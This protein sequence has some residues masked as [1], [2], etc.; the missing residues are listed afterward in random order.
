MSDVAL[1]HRPALPSRALLWA[2]LLALFVGAPLLMTAFFGRYS[3]FAVLWLLAGVAA[4]L[5]W[6]TP[7]FRWRALLR[8]PVLGEWR[9]IA[10]FTLF[11]A[12]IAAA[13]AQALVPHAFLWMP[14]G[15]PG[16]WVMI[17]LLYPPLSALPQ[18]LI[19]RT[20]FF[21]RYGRL[22]PSA[23]AAVAANGALFGLGH[24]F[25]M[26]PL[27]IGATALAGAAFGWAY[28]RAGSTLLSW[29]LHAIG[30][31]LVFTLGLGRFFYHGA[32][33]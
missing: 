9:L 16:L 25:Y 32:V 20:L 23:R 17:M 13:T 3:L 21:E 29:A 30:G 8:G 31:M 33:G 22:F 1:A 26:N 7:E 28:L 5:L 24:L 10:G 11:T 2:E 6:R 18:E 27:T 4:Y 15:A 12:L 19:Y 14:F